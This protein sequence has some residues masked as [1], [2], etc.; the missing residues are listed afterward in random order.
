MDPL[1]VDLRRTITRTV[2]V[3]LFRTG[4]ITAVV[5]LALLLLQTSFDPLSAVAIAVVA[6]ELVALGRLGHALLTNPLAAPYLR[7]LTSEPVRY[8]SAP[9]STDW[10]HP[11]VA[12]LTP[13]GLERVNTLQATS[14]PDQPMFD[15]LETPDHMV[16]AAV[17]RASGT[18]TLTTSFDDGRVL[19]T[20]QQLVPPSRWLIVN[21]IPDDDVHAV[22]RGH[23]RAVAML[24][25][26]GVAP[27]FTGVASFHRVMDHEWTGYRELGP[28]LGALL[29]IDGGAGPLRLAYT[30][31]PDEILE[32]GIRSRGPLSSTGPEP[33]AAP[34]TI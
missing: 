7:Q 2:G 15:V 10:P 32:L 30:P 9:A 21:Q 8:V 33:V 13:Y 29:D 12:E 4:V 16:A 24:K 22:A 31:T 5:V 27:T 20:S 19:C 26:S 1:I 11:A 14:A 23:R 18:V 6:G 3:R 34:A 17:G 28:V 25:A